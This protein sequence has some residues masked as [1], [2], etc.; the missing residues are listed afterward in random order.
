[1]RKLLF[2]TALIALNTGC[3][4]SGQVW[5]IYLEQVD[6]GGNTQTINHNYNDAQPYDGGPVTGEWT[7]TNSFMTSST[8]VFAQLIASKG[9]NDGYLLFGETAIPGAKTKEGWTFTWSD[10]SQDAERE[11]HVDGYFNA[12]NSTDNSTT[13]LTMVI[14][15]NTATGTLEADFTDT[16]RYEEADMWNNDDLFIGSSIPAA[17]YLELSDG[18]FV[19]NAPETADCAADCFLEIVNSGKRSQAFTAERTAVSDDAAMNYIGNVGSP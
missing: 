14:D 19:T 9:D 2:A 3:S 1:M 10:D 13:T 5:A 16:T 6:I 18:G 15:G 12:E 7:Y 8:L 11:E 17:N 4:Q